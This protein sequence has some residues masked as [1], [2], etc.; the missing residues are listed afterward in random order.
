MLNYDSEDEW[1]VQSLEW[2]Q[3]IVDEY[4]EGIRLY[5]EKFVLGE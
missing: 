5:R 1:V 2:D 4:N 3:Q